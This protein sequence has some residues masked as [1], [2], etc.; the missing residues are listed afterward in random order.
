MNAALQLL[1]SSPEPTYDQLAQRDNAYA[2]LMAL[3]NTGG[4]NAHLFARMLSGV[5]AHQGALAARLGL[6]E[7]DYTHMLSQYFGGF[8][9]PHDPQQQGELDLDRLPERD[10]LI[11]LLLEYRAGNDESERWIAEIISAACMGMDHLWQ[12]LALWS[13][14]DL[15]E[16]IKYNFPSLAEK[17][18]RDMKW[19]K[20]LYKQLCER[21][22]IYVCRAPSCDVCNDYAN[23]FG[24][25]E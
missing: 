2:R 21:E 9:W 23:C 19:K 13:R 11:D 7:Q 6:S 12:D 18:N 24:P 16:M 15:S 10:D 22:G 1:A 4:L 14:R 25:E 3:C 5:S 17:N 20:F 8:D